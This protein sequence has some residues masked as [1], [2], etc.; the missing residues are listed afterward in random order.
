MSAAYPLRFV[1]VLAALLSLTAAATADP[2][3]MVPPIYTGPGQP[4]TRV[5]L[6]ETYV[7]YKDGIE[8]FIIRPGYEG[9][10]DEFGM[11]IPFPK[12]PALR[13]VSDNIFPHMA[14]AIDPPEVVVYV[15]QF[16]LQQNSDRLASAPT[17]QALPVTGALAY[18]EVRIVRQEAVGMYEVAVIEAGSPAALKK[19]MDEHGYKYPDGMDKAC[20]EYVKDRWCFVAVKTK[21]GAKGGADPQPAQRDV[22]VKLPAGSTFDGHVQA[23]GFR[24]PTDELVVPMRL[25]AFNEGELRNIVYLLTDSPQKIRSIPEEYVVRQISGDDLLRNV[26]QPLPLRIIGGDVS[27]IPDWRKKTLPEERKPEPH[28]GAARDA[29]ASDLLAVASGEL[30]L[31]HEEK[32]KELLA[33]GERFGLRGGEIDALHEEFLTEQREAAVVSALKD[34]KGMSLTVVDGDF[35]REVLARKN[36]QFAQYKM[37]A[38]R[39]KAEVYDTKLKAPTG[40]KQGVLKL[41]AVDWDK[42]DGQSRPRVPSRPGD[43]KNVA[44][45]YRPSATAGLLLAGLILGGAALFGRRISTRAATVG[46]IV[47]LM[48]STAWAD[49]CGMVPPIYTGDGQPITRVGEQMTFV[50]FSGRVETFVIRPGFE[51]KVDEFGMLIPFPKPPALRKVPDHIFMHIAQAIDPPEVIVDLFPP[52]PAPSAAAFGGSGPVADN[53]LQ[54]ARRDVVRVLKQEAVGMYEV[55]VLEAGSAAALKKWMDQHGYKYPDG[56]DK[57]CEEYVDDRWCFVAVKTK[58]GQKDGVDPQPAQ[59]D[60]K[61]KLPA[62]STFDGNVQ[63]MGFRFE[64][65]ELVVPMRLSAFNAGDLRNIVYLLT[66]KPQKIRAIPEEYV[67]RQISGDELHR[68]VTGPL[69]LRILGGTEADLTEQHRKNLVSQRNPEP[70]NGA[71]RDLFAGDLLAVATGELSLEHEEKEKELLAIGERLGLRGTEIDGLHE[72][73]LAE[74]RKATVTKSIGSLKKMSLTVIDGEFPR[75]VLGKHNLMFASYEMPARR[76]KPAVYEASSKG[77]GRDREGRAGDR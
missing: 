50:F 48:A 53:G 16:L 25:A 29:F 22:N 23:M 47:L 54:Y 76:N 36:L 55:A 52:P 38:R 32:E 19:W 42:V 21:V 28:N 4:I 71:A 9:K 41:G 69:P 70:K 5:G 26:T 7:F 18:N 72:E 66:D 49:P 33:I 35:P 51:G 27:Q 67:V 17:N 20:E 77:P 11:L 44:A 60:V 12:P 37:P 3:G 43:V 10:V 64:T 13:K 56:M 75:E 59:R 39:N 45:S 46:A 74:M 14:A 34:L 58:V 31:P 24:F 63:A 73:S 62:G 6:Q 8:T 15:Q 1:T 2:C 57:V 40:D 30:S 61:S 68:N 65:D